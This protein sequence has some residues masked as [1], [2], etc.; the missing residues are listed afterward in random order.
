MIL[1]LTCSISDLFDY[2]SWQKINYI[3]EKLFR[4][5]QYQSCLFFVSIRIITFTN[6]THW[7]RQPLLQSCLMLICDKSIVIHAADLIIA[8]WSYMLFSL[9]DCYWNSIH[10]FR[11]FNPRLALESIHNVRNIF[12]IYQL[13]KKKW[14]GEP[15]TQIK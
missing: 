5:K 1:Y 3:Q 7:F 11:L 4:K 13:I 9:S 8:Y 12:Q 6:Q 10:V 15:I 14:S 2:F